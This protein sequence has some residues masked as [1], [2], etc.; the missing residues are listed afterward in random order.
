MR[1]LAILLVVG[2]VPTWSAALE[3]V[4][5]TH[6]LMAGEMTTVSLLAQEA[7]EL[8]YLEVEL[9]Y[10]WAQFRLLDVKPG[11]RFV[12]D[13]ATMATN[14][15]ALPDSSGRF[16]FAAAVPSGING[17]VSLVDLVFAVAETVRDSAA[18]EL[19][20]A[21]A[22][23]LALQEV[24]IVLPEGGLAVFTAVEEEERLLPETPAL[25]A[26]F[27]NPFNA[28]TL[29]PFQL[30]RPAEV[31]LQVYNLLGQVVRRFVMGRLP[32]GYYDGG[33]AVRW[34]GR[35]SRGRQV[36]SGVYLVRLEAGGFTQIQKAL[37]LR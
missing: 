31:E 28:S 37:L 11:A 34:D 24:E 17:T 30:A 25:L 7:R 15:E 12:Q 22:V 4:I 19:R 20:A 16:R 32:A 1:K 9:T 36:A 27:P 18:I 3:L 6:P 26:N 14:P 35:D 2:L 13:D 33:R 5:Q 23:D 21:Q 8:G 10:D 29:L